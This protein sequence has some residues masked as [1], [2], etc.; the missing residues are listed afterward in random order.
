MKLERTRRRATS[1]ATAGF[2]L[3]E[4]TIT[5]TLMVTIFSALAVGV[6]AGHV[7]NAEIERRVALAVQADDIMDRLFR[8]DF[9]QASDGAATAAQLSALFDDD[10]DLGTC[11]LT[12]LRVYSGAKGYTFSLANFP[13]PGQFEVRVSTDLNG[14]GDETDPNEGTSEVFRI[15]VNFIDASGKSERIMECIRARPTG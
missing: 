4:M 10:E 3:I 12:N 5:L 1:R 11:T 6:R 7:A 13:Y 2:T 8:I 9:G 14:D 15:D